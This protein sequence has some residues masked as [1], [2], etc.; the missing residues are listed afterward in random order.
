MTRPTLRT[1]PSVPHEMATTEPATSAPVH[2]ALA[3]TQAQ[4]AALLNVSKSTVERLTATGALPSVRIGGCRRVRHDD[5]TD[6][7]ATLSAD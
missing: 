2:P 6:Y 1:V 4:A 5:L 3:Y 7:L